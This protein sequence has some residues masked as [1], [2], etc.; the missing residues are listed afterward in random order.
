MKRSST[1]SG[2]RSTSAT[3]RRRTSRCSVPRTSRRSPSRPFRTVRQSSF[4][5]WEARPIGDGISSKPPT[6]SSAGFPRPSRRRIF[7]WDEIQNRR[8]E[9]DFKTLTESVQRCASHRRGLSSWYRERGRRIRLPA[10]GAHPSRVNGPNLLRLVAYSALRLRTSCW[11][12][13][14]ALSCDSALR[15]TTAAQTRLPCRRIRRPH[16]DATDPSLTPVGVRQTHERNLLETV[17]K[18]TRSG[19]RR[20]GPPRPPRRRLPRDKCR[21]RRGRVGQ[22]GD[23]PREQVL[24]PLRGDQKNLSKKSSRCAGLAY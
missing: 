13:V 4:G 15:T 9:V 5:K 24:K 16:G 22:T 17:S 23:R 10:A 18:H 19:W 6:A 20:S 21:W 12:C 3:K 11:G 8:L 7:V 1:P 2:K 14:S